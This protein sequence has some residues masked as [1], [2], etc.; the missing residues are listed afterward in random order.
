[1]NREGVRIL[2]RRLQ[3]LKEPSEKDMQQDLAQAAAALI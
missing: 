2:R 1:L 3:Q